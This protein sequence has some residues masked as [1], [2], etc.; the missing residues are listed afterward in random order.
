MPSAFFTTDGGDII[1][2]AGP[3]TGS[4]HDFCVHKTILSL[5]SPVFKDML[6]FP[7]PL[8]QTSDEQHQ[9][10][11]VVIPESPEVFDIILRFIY[12]GV[13]PPLKITKR[14]TLSALLFMAD[15][16][17]IPS[18]YPMLRE[19]L[20]ARLSPY[21]DHC[22]WV[23]VMACRF[24]FSEV[25][26]EAAKWSSKSSLSG[27]T[28][29]ED[30][31]HVSSTDLYR[32]VQFVL[33]RERDG[34]MTIRAT[35]EV[36]PREALFACLHQGEDVEVYYS[37]LQKEVEE[38]FILNPCVGVKDLS[39]VHDEVPD[40]PLGCNPLPSPACCYSRDEGIVNFD[41]P[42]RP[43]TIR[44]KLQDIANSFFQNNILLLDEFFGRDFG[45]G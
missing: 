27:L 29:S 9:L 41:C 22:L 23:Y 19:S 33:A 36:V 45:S 17:D 28:N 26:K 1:L 13:E 6:A 18:I 2:R 11:V 16:Y 44:R 35:L 40:P 21:S 4:N 5:A 25:A 31:R 10:P 15:K 7:Q 42:L 43:M 24:G 32:L 39:M 20:K 14:S 8:D 34:L 38:A 37:C 12:P 3:E 30:I